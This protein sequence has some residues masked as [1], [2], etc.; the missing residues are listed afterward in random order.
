VSPQL[1]NNPGFMCTLFHKKEEK[2]SEEALE[3]KGVYM[4]DG[5]L[6]V[7]SSGSL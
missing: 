1:G 7:F 2:A 6:R 5:S 3:K 4:D